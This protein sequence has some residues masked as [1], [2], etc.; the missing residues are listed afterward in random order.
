MKGHDVTPLSVDSECYNGAQPAGP[1][2]SKVILAEK[3][4]NESRSQPKSQDE[5]KHFQFSN[6]VRVFPAEG[7]KALLFC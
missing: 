7:K 6:V 2:V 3:S 4:D 5:G 1:E